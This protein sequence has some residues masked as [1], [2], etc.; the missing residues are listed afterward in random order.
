MRQ[1]RIVAAEANR[2]LAA[3]IAEDAEFD[4]AGPRTP[5]LT[6]SVE[7]RQDSRPPDRGISGF[8]V[9]PVVLAHVD[10]RMTATPDEDVKIRPTL[11]AGSPLTAAYA[12]GGLI[13]LGSDSSE[14]YEDGD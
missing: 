14:E 11:P 12:A 4:G 10:R 8:A 1:A 13:F 2:R 7:P 6:A 3:A 5:S 9:P